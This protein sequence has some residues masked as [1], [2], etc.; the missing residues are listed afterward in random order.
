MRCVDRDPPLNR[1]I[2]PLQSRN[3]L[4][5]KYSRFLSLCTF[6]S[7]ASYGNIEIGVYEKIILTVTLSFFCLYIFKL[8]CLNII[9]LLLN[10]LPL[11]CNDC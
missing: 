10:V 9:N 5:V 3:R 8:I 6:M 1:L 11:V 2:F 4:A 7:N